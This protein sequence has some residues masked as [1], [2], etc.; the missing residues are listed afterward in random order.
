MRQLDQ[1]LG[2]I[3]KR[4]QDELRIQA[5]FNGIQLPTEGNSEPTAKPETTEAEVA[6]M[7]R[8]REEAKLRKAQEFARRHG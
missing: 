7:S 2:V 6:A 4:V 5:A 1:L 3:N 8:A